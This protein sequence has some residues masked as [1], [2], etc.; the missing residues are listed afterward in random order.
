M[1][2]VTRI[3]LLIIL[4]L[5]S[6]GGTAPG[7]QASGSPAKPTPAPTPVPLARVPLEAQSALASLQEIDAN[8]AGDQA[9]A[10]GIA[11]T[12]LGLTGEI[13]PRIAD[14]SRLLT[15]SPSLD[16]L[17]RLKLAWE[18]FGVRLLVSA[19]ELTRHATSLEEQLARVDQLNKTWQA[20]LQSAKQP[21]TPPQVLQSVQ[22]VVDSIERTRQAA[23]SGRD[24]VLTLQSHVSEQEAR[25][26]TALSSIDRAETRALQNIFVRDSLP[27]WRLGTSLGTEWE[28][29][30]GESISS[31]LEKRLFPVY[32]RSRRLS[33]TGAER[34]AH[35]VALSAGSEP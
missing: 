1:H 29:H 7:Q 17:Y 21:E 16:M 12:L 32:F 24:H 8:V 25:V 27:I 11:S 9:S 31:Q 5:V 20:T 35:A 30:G 28:Q 15:T 2:P 33:V 14:D 23:E 6:S 26:R 13:E 4:A 18:N 22:S 10:D 19:R 34:V 3:V